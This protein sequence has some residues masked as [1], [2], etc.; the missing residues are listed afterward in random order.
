MTIVAVT[1][2]MGFARKV[3]NRI[4]FFDG[5]MIVEEN[6]PQNFFAIPQEDRSKRFLNRFCRLID[7]HGRL[8]VFLTAAE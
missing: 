5:G 6:T 4:L 1:H 8:L 2:E 3:A 7:H